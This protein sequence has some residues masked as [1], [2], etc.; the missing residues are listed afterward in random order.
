M[1]THHQDT[2]PADTGARVDSSVTPSPDDS[3]APLVHAPAGTFHGVQFRGANSFLGIRYGE[4]SAG[5]FRPATAYR[6]TKT[7]NAT[8]F[9]D[10]APQPDMRSEVDPHSAEI[11]A[12]L[13][14]GSGSPLENGAMSEDCLN[15]N[16]WAPTRDIEQVKSTQAPVEPLPVMVWFHGGAYSSG[17]ANERCFMGD[18]LAAHGRVIV[19]SVSHRL[20]ALGF[21]HLGPLLGEAFADSANAGLHDLILALS[22][23]RE[24]IAAFGGD[25]NNVTIF[26]QSGGGSKVAALLTTPHAGKL[27]HKAIMQSGVPGMVQRPEEAEKHAARLVEALGA[28]RILT[29]DLDELLVAQTMLDAPFG[30]A[31]TLDARLLHEDP[32]REQTPAAAVGLP[33]IVGHATHDMAMMLPAGTPLEAAKHATSVTFGHSADRVADAA[34]Q[35]GPVYRYEFAYE[36]EALGGS[37]GACHSLDLPFTFGTVD[38]IP[39]AGYRTER[40]AVS[41][42]MMSAWSQ[43]ARTGSPGADWPLYTAGGREIM[44]IDTDRRVESAPAT[45]EQSELPW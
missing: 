32:F 22:W 30:L 11:L 37:I 31:P 13:Y 4:L 42:F 15:L 33:L 3:N 10:R 18:R 16:V 29:C 45:L 35:S 8:I 17:S 38:Y 36:T 28:D 12:L 26:G 2:T 19:V 5:R 1:G 21:L 41:A 27:F 25:P 44:V 34:V 43:F 23:V 7:V 9:G 39:F 14:P 40:F 6:S 24:N 20:G